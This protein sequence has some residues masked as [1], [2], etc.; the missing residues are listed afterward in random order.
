MIY[1]PERFQVFEGVEVASDAFTTRMRFL[2]DTQP[3]LKPCVPV[4][5]DKR[6][7]TRQESNTAL[8]KKK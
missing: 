3:R 2:I 1:V 5:D 6:I 8:S 4:A 7:H